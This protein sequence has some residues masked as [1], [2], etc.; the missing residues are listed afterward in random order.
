MCNKHLYEVRLRATI[1]FSRILEHEIFADA[2][3]SDCYK[4]YV[5]CENFTNSH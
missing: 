2:R 1:Q 4:L 3:F 5:E